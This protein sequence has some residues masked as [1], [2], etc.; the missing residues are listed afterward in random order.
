MERQV[1]AAPELA[2]P[3]DPAFYTALAV[4]GALVLAAFAAGACLP[5]TRKNL[6]P[7]AG[8]VWFLVGFLP[9]SNL[10]SLNASVAEHWLYLPSIGFLLFLA[11]I[12]LDLPGRRFLAARPED[13]GRRLSLMVGR[14]VGEP[15]RAR[16]TGRTA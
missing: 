1:F 3:A 8:A 4:A 11:G 13:R 16:T 15:G 12:A 9:I 5:G 14:W 6:A 7:R 10:F 2:N